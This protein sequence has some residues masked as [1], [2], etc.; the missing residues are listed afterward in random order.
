MNPNTLLLSVDFEDWHQLV[1]RRLGLEGWEK[2]GPALGR[3]TD[4]LLALFEALGVRATFFVLG[5]AARSHPGLVER[6]AAAGHEIGCHGDAHRLVSSQ[7]RDEFAADIRAGRATIEQLT[8]SRPVGYRAPAFSI[9]SQTPWAYEVLLDEGFAYDASEHDSPLL[10]DQM[11]AR[12]SGPRPLET[13]NGHLWEFPVAIWR[14]PGVNVPVGGASYWSVMPTRSVVN[15]LAAAGPH[16][17]I[18]LHPYELDPEPL[19]L[20]LPRTMTPV[21]RAQ[22]L[23]RT[24]QRNLARQRT[25]RVLRAIAAHH[26]LVPYGEAYAELSRGVASR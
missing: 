1:R 12:P 6:I 15:G 5:I 22:G 7:T 4:Q 13:R 17:G 26:D 21:Q 8:G 18:Y 3:Q 14:R 2:P 20:S 9:T 23:V 19:R 10:R 25:P 24:A 11:S 16:A